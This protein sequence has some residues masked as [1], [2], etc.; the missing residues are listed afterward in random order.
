MKIFEAF[1]EILIDFIRWV[2]YISMYKI[3][4]VPLLERQRSNLF[5]FIFW[6]AKRLGLFFYLFGEKDMFLGNRFVVIRIQFKFW[7]S[8][9]IILFLQS[10]SKNPLELFFDRSL[11]FITFSNAVSPDSDEFF[12]LWKHSHHFLEQVNFFLFY[13]EVFVS[14]LHHQNEMNFLYFLKCFLH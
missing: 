8:I 6:K 11:I 3:R 4:W 2:G 12:T 13:L 7:L 1:E 5:Y 9:F 14:H 10:F